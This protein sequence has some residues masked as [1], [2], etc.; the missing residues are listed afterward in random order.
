MEQVTRKGNGEL[1]DKNI[2]AI[3]T[4][5]SGIVAIIGGFMKRELPVLVFRGVILG[6]LLWGVVLI[7]LMIRKCYGYDKRREKEYQKKYER[8]QSRG[9]GIIFREWNIDEKYRKKK[10]NAIC[11]AAVKGVIMLVVIM[12]V[13]WGNPNNT[14]AFVEDMFH[15]NKEDNSKEKQG[16]ENEEEVGIEIKEND[17]DQESK[18]K[19]DRSKETE[20]NI[21]EEPVQVL[22]EKKQKD[23][24]FKILNPDQ[25]YGL[26]KEMAQQVYFLIEDSEIDL[27][28][29]VLSYFT[30]IS[31]EK[32]KEVK[33][34]EIED[35]KGNTPS[36][37]NEMQNEFE[38]AVR[39]SVNMEYRDEWSRQAP[40]SD[41]L[42][43]RI[44][45]R[46]KLC[47]IKVEEGTGHHELWWRLANDYQYY[48]Q[49]YEIQ[50]NNGGMIYYY[51]TMSIWCCMEALQY[52]L[53]EEEE[54][55]IYTFMVTRYKDIAREESL[56]EE[57][58]KE[59]A[60]KI[61]EILENY[62]T[63]P[64]QIT[65]KQCLNK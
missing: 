9:N 22:K 2:M 10:K 64:A 7:V 54:N 5:M 23:Y 25:I 44:N 34:E 27:E 26:Q 19:E 35:E 38:D 14:K 63:F 51:Y 39:L 57:T 17:G 56:V 29:N 30:R 52:D 48:A 31:E 6:L 33:Y 45:G 18:K 62:S 15:I 3:V 58:Y 41:E 8:A 43:V 60:G 16:E 20:E 61:A 37:Y 50:T 32:K 55:M 4:I 49:E 24:R 53:P 13:C 65:P 40:T 12:L 21:S 36:F 11:I 28:E 59:R 46:R 1:F 47:N 42:D